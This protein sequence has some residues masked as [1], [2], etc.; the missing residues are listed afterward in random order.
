MLN[1][2]IKLLTLLWCYLNLKIIAMNKETAKLLKE[3]KLAYS[4]DMNISMNV[5]MHIPFW[6][7]FL[8][9][10]DERELLSFDEDLLRNYNIAKDIK[11]KC[12][13][14]ANYN[15]ELLTQLAKLEYQS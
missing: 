9:K 5:L 15:K 2:G 1:R 13:K 8:D 4:V 7:P 14:I 11:A 12:W 6:N 3:Y 10:E